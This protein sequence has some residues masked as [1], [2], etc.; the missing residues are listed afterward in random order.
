MDKLRKHI[1][2]SF[3]NPVLHF[4][5]LLV[6]L[7]VDD[8]FGIKL[9]WEISFPFTLILL[10]YI[11][12]VFNRIFTWHLIFTMIFVCVSLITSFLP[13][14]F[15]RHDIICESVVLLFLVALI[16][17]RKQ[18][19]LFV[20]HAMSNLIPM[21]NNIEELYR[22]LW[23]FALV[24]LIY[25]SGFLIVEHLAQDIKPFHEMLQS[26][27]IGTLSFLAVYEII[28]V[29]IIR[30]RLIK[31][32]WVPIV[33]N[34]GKI[35][36]SIQHQTSLHDEMKYQHPIIRIL[37]VE[38]GMVLLNKKTEETNKSMDFW[39]TTLVNYVVMNETIEQCVERTANQM[40]GINN[41]KY[42]YVSNYTIDCKNENQ[43]A[44]LFVSCM[45]TDLNFNA[46]YSETTKWWTKPQIEDNLQTGIFSD[47]FIAEYDLIKRSGLLETDKCECNCRLK[48]TIYN[49]MK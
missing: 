22:V 3:F 2:E 25:I 48:E 39:D 11:Y 35:I 33:N 41:F 7:V 44:F 46:E 15:I 49:Q 10:S 28:R 24:L 40:L 1:K 17:F 18:F 14:T 8:F 9:A 4:L 20:N 47:N 13:S 42:M 38:N 37:F 21:S 5:P 45:Q 30:S 36:G 16:V 19:K 34:K 6:F 26:L 31:E 32:E 43:Y 29:Q 23:A 12:F 27:Y